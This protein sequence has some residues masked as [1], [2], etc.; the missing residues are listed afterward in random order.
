MQWIAQLNYKS[1]PN[2]ISKDRRALCSGVHLCVCALSGGTQ[3]LMW[4]ATFSG[5]QNF[6]TVLKIYV[7]K[8]FRGT[9]M[10]AGL[11]SRLQHFQGV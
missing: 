6:Q 5:D 2:A 7:V 1:K 10:S 4:E 3:S 9:E 11:N 8:S